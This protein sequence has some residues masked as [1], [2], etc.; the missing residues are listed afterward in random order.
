MPADFVLHAA[1][2]AIRPRIFALHEEVFRPH[3]EQ[4]WGWHED[5]QRENFAG[6]W[7]SCETHWIE[8][9]GKLVGHLQTLKNADH[10]LLKN[11]A[12]LPQFQG[13][14][15]AQLWWDS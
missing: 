7:K 15:L 9:E 13:G 11:L 3:I 5:W 2:E 10:L 12:L 6:N 4:I 1:D 8:C 14:A